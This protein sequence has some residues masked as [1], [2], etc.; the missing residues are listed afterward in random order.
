MP[1]T[2]AKWIRRS[3]ISL[4]TL[5]VLLIAL[6]CLRSFGIDYAPL[7]DRIWECAC[8]RG[9]LVIAATDKYH[10]NGWTLWRN[11]PGYVTAYVKDNEDRE[12]TH[13]TRIRIAP[14]FLYVSD[15]PYLQ[16]AIPLWLF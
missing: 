7:H 6:S 4:Y 13:F 12:F 16:L 14:R 8:D 10:D 1:K 5:L 15:G 11:A 2:A 9:V 3:L